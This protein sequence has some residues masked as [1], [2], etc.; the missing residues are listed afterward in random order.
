M[1]IYLIQ[2]INFL[3][4]IYHG[5]RKSY[6]P[7]DIYAR[8]HND[9]IN[10]IT[11][12]FLIVFGVNV[13]VKALE[14]ANSKLL[15]NTMQNHSNNIWLCLFTGLL[16]TMLMQS[17][18]ATVGLTILLFNSGLMPFSSAVAPTLGDNIGSCITVQIASLSSGTAGKRSAW[19]HT[20]YNIIGVVFALIV[21]PQFCTIVQFC[22]H[23]AGQDNHRLVANAHTILTF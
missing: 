13:M 21:L 18:S 10:F 7:E 17:S 1:F 22:T 8:C 16:V 19:A 6:L 3:N 23:L 20:I 4:F 11:G 5:I 15:K 14:Y 9:F 12:S 2:S